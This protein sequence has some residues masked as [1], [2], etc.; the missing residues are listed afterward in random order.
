MVQPIRASCV[1]D[2]VVDW[3][4]IQSNPEVVRHKAEPTGSRVQHTRAEMMSPDY[5]GWPPMSKEEMN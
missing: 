1:A 5:F 4:V 3:F 2:D